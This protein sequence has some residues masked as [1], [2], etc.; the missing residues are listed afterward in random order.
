MVA[1]VHRVGNHKI[2]TNMSSTPLPMVPFRKRVW[3]MIDTI[4]FIL[5]LLSALGCGLMAGVFFIFSN[6][7][8]GALAQLQPPQGIAAMQSI[9]RTILN[10]LFFV[11][12]LG[13]A[14]T[15]TLLAISLLWRW[16]HP[17]TAYLL[18]GSL[19]YLIGT[20]LVTIVFN[21]PMNEALDSVEPE[22]IEAANQWTK[23][24]TN[25]TAWNHIRTAASILGTL[26]FIL[27]LG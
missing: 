7:V 5:T 19:F 26:S 16:Q 3:A 14:A 17:G 18:A 22:S 10:P 13:T 27:A 2:M 4:F 8:M 25:W 20:I 1:S 15:T 21:V 11:A 24:L 23:Y 9:N 6:T 12:F